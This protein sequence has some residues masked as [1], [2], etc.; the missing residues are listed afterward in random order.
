MIYCEAHAMPTHMPTT[1]HHWGSWPYLARTHDHIT[2]LWLPRTFLLMAVSHSPEFA[3]SCSAAS[4]AFLASVVGEV[5]QA[6]ILCRVTRVISVFIMDKYPD[7]ASEPITPTLTKSKNTTSLYN[8]TYLQLFE[9]PNLS[10]ALKTTTLYCKLFT[11]FSSEA[12]TI[13][14]DLSRQDDSTPFLLL[15]FSF[16]PEIEGIPFSLSAAE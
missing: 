9:L 3:Q 5:G 2:M 7:D 11:I 12:I 16:G 6:G 13:Y 4:R 8:V 14:V 15:L 1:E 10:E